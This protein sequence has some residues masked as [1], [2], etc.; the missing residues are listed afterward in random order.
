[1]NELQDLRYSKTTRSN[2]C[3]FTAIYINLIKSNH[4]AVD[5]TPKMLIKISRIRLYG[6][7][8]VEKCF[9]VHRIFV[10]CVKSARR[11]GDV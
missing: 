3:Q 2:I 8:R 7:E 5:K 9:T 10:F 6:D 11:L 1:M 4:I